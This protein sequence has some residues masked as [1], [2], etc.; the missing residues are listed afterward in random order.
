MSAYIRNAIEVVVS[1]D[2]AVSIVINES[3]ERLIGKP[4]K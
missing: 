3:P 1:K 2:V 4:Y